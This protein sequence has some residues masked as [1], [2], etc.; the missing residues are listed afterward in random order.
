MFST[1]KQKLLLGVYI[2]VILS[3]PIGSYLASSYQTLKSSASEPKS[4][5]GRALNTDAP[6]PLST[7]SAKLKLLEDALKN[8]TS[9]NT[10]T[11]NNTSG[12][13]SESP[14]IASSFGAT[15]SLLVQ[16][17]GRPLT[18]QSAKLF[19]GIIEGTVGSNPKFLLSFTVDLSTNGT[20][21]NLSLAGLDIGKEYTAILKGPSQIATSSAFTVAPTVTKLNNGEP[22]LLLTGD[23]NDDNIINTS[24]YAVLQ[25]ALG[26]ISGSEKWNDN[27]DFNIDGV[28]N[29]F[30]LAFITRNFGRTGISGSW[31][32]PT[33]S[34]EASSSATPTATS[35]GGL[36]PPE[37]AP[38]GSTGDGYWIWVPSR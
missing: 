25:S 33:P 27:L 32:S 37:K 11:S 31:Y 13:S 17:E 14:T 30:D 29:L 6:P 24:D 36:T 2:F 5:S 18:N 10:T 34:P 8:T 21:D 3:I 20:Y 28:I 22:I 23:V 12:T 38:Q 35:S 26:A 1:F 7:Q 16:L 4:T 15:M 9:S 19:V